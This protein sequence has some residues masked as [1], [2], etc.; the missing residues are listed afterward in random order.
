MLEQLDTWLFY[1]VNR[2]W[3]NAVFDTVMPVASNLKFFY[4]PLALCWIFLLIRKGARGR[5][6]AV[7][8]LLLLSLSE[9][10]SSHI[11]KPVFDRPRPYHVLSGVHLYDRMFKTW[12]VTPPLKEPVLGESLSLPSSHAT[13]IFAA[14][15]FL[16]YFFRRLWPLFYLVA[17]V[18]GYSRV[19]LGVHFPLDVA[20][21]AAVGTV[22]A[23]VTVFALEGGL[24]LLR[25]RT[26]LG[27]SAVP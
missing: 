21:G 5:R 19:Y 11:L 8:V 3:Q 27:R 17:A 12:S 6:A 9:T 16:A 1:L 18:V 26:G 14:A 25:R 23:S 13:N 4:V 15:A 7:G 24:H 10:M 2:S 20:V 22:C